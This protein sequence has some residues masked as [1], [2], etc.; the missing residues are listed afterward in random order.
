MFGDV[1]GSECRMDRWYDVSMFG[2][3]I[4]GDSVATLECFTFAAVVASCRTRSGC[5]P[6]FNE[7]S[8]LARRISNGCCQAESSAVPTGTADVHELQ[9]GAPAAVPA[10]CDTE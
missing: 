5:I 7:L 4:V 8:M 2:A 9:L 3:F 6:L 1:D 10:L